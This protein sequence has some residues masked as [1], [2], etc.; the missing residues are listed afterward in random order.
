[1]LVKNQT[2]RGEKKEKLN[3]GRQR[4][5]P[6]GGEGGERWAASARVVNKERKGLIYPPPPAV[7]LAF[8]LLKRE[9]GKK[10]E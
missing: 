5:R 6:R 2:E 10:M 9:T 3:S 4:R 8:L 1:M 7:P